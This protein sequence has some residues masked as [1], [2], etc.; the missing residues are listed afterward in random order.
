[1]SNREE[2]VIAWTTIPTEI[3]GRKFARELLDGR[4][5]SCVS[6]FQAMQSTFRWN[7]K[8]EANDEHAVMIKTTRRRVSSLENRILELHN[9]D[10][11]EFVVTTISDGH[12][13]YLDWVRR[14]TSE[15]GELIDSD[16]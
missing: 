5:A 16:D 4:L 13:P 7:G 10:V 2:V 14:E 3:D 6:V 15:P 9:Y 12:V 8:V 1:M 11:P